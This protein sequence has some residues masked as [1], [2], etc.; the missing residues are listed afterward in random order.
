MP[1]RRRWARAGF[2]VV[3]LLSLVVLFTPSS[4][5]PDVETNDKFVHAGLFALLALSGL[6]AELAPWPLVV[7][8]V[9]YA[10]LSEVLQAVLPINRDG[11]VHD[12]L[13]DCVGIAVAT[14]L[15]LGGRRITSRRTSR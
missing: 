8:L 13:A 3:V 15:V 14:L 1:E 7:L 6:L 2:A 12:S 10:G 5:V 11:D 9:A 4:H